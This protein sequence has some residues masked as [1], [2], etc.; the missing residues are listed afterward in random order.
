VRTLRE[1]PQAAA[2]RP[3]LSVIIPLGPAEPA[4]PPLFDELALLPPGSE[5]L[6]VG[7]EPASS[8]DV[9]AVTEEQLAAHLR[10]RR[11]TAP[12]GRASQMNLGAQRASG[13]YLWF[14]H[15]DSRLTPENVDALFAAIER[16]PLSLLYFDLQFYDGPRR[17]LRLNEWGARL[18][19]D[20]LGV[21]FGDQG[22]CLHRQQF[23]AIGGYPV[24][25]PYGEDHLFVWHARQRG[26]RLNR[27]ASRLATSARKYRQRGWARLTLLYQ[28]LWLRQAW[29]QWKTLW[30]IRL[31][32]RQ[33]PR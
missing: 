33:P 16:R 12:R 24:A 4:R 5:I 13:T 25:A 1:S 2:P 7:C 10:I 11:L 26:I 8:S 22:F 6:L 9:A 18:R 23:A 30:A 31:G 17:C 28:W 3:L 29:P 19:S 32:L 14:L 20:W 27:T 21:P 15:A